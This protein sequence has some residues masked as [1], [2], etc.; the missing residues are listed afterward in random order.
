MGKNGRQK[1][2]GYFI[3]TLRQQNK[4]RRHI[5]DMRDLL[6]HRWNRTVAFSCAHCLTEAYESE[7][8][9]RT[10]Y[11]SDD[12]LIASSDGKLLRRRQDATCTSECGRVS[13]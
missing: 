7:I 4:N 12:E 2:G 8:G 3:P 10:G 11:V 13:T 5:F 1:T 6:E 9:H